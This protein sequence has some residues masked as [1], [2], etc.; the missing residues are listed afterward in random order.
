[1]RQY[2]GIRADDIVVADFYGPEYGRTG[3]KEIEISDFRIVADNNG[4]VENVSVTDFRVDSQTGVNRNIR[5][6][7]SNAGTVFP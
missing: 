4:S 5:F 2:N 3:S 6:S 1:M 7:E